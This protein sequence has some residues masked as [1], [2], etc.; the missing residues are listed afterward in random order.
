MARDCDQP[1]SLPLGSVR[2]LLTFLLVAITAAVLFV[3][4][5]EESDEVKSM[6][7]LLTGIAVRDYF[8]S[9]AEAARSA[10]SEASGRTA[11]IASPSG[12]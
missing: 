3:P 5:S 9:R 4:V 10:R 2:A 1:L 8:H 12:A 11:G 6:F 7:V